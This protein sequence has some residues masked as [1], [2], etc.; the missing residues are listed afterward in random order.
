MCQETPQVLGVRYS[1]EHVL[2]N[3]GAR[4]ARHASALEVLFRGSGRA[5]KY[6]AARCHEE[7]TIQQVEHCR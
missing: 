7:S 5:S 1:V 4:W 6:H 2:S 3:G